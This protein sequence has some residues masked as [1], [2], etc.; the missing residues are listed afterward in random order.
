MVEVGLV[1]GGGRVCFC[2]GQ[3]VGGVWV[4]CNRGETVQSNI[5]EY[6]NAAPV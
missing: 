1:V 6:Y 4:E 5:F 2:Y 3:W